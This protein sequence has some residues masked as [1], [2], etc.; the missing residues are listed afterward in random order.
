ME[1]LTLA[2][3]GKAVNSIEDI[4]VEDLGFAETVYQQDLGEDKY[5]FVEGCKNPRSCTILV[6]GQN[7]HTIAQM[8]DAVRDGVRAVKNTIEDG[9]V[10]PGAG[11]FEVYCY[12]QL[13]EFKKTVKGKVKMAVQAFADSITCIPKVLAQ[14]SGF[15]AQDI[16]LEL[17]DE[18][19][20]KKTPVGVNVLEKGI[21]SPELAGI[22]DNVVVKKQFLN[23]APTLAQQLILCDEILKAGKKMG[24]GG[25]G[26][27]PGMGGPGGMPMGMQMPGM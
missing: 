25:P 6:K 8:K 11:A 19:N 13:Q 9:A 22:Y 17:I 10:L 15:D 14:N 2:C 3:G 1:R 20:E 16:L 4:T 12:T 18:Y 24:K 27:P 26:G 21:I 5:T 7:D 23:L